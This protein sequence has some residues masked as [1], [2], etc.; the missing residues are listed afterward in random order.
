ML[1]HSHGKIQKKLKAYGFNTLTTS[2]Q[3]NVE[4]QQLHWSLLYGF[5][6]WSDVT[7][8]NVPS[9]RTWPWRG[10]KLSYTQAGPVLPW[11]PHHTTVRPTAQ[12]ENQS[13]LPE[14][15]SV[16]SYPNK[17]GLMPLFRAGYKSHESLRIDKFEDLVESQSVRN[18]FMKFVTDSYLIV[19]ISFNSW[20]I[21]NL[22][23]KFWAVQNFV[24]KTPDFKRL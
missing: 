15:T 23:Q 5:P 8:R 22:W 17:P 16:G 1:V 18:Q 4:E 12:G 19:V 10:T 21:G 3:R 6:I 24:N 13:G 2:P 7:L 9:L 14:P 11:K 20:A